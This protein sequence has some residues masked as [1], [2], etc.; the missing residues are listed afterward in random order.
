LLATF[1]QVLSFYSIF[2]SVEKNLSSKLYISV[3]IFSLSSFFLHRK[4]ISVLLVFEM[5]TGISLLS[6]FFSVCQNKKS[7]SLPEDFDISPSCFRSFSDQKRRKCQP[8]TV[9]SFFLANHLF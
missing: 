8:F 3:S 9:P 1:L 4:A 5:M 6:L 7:L 2:L